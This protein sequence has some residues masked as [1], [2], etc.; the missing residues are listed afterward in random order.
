MGKG[1]TDEQREQNLMKLVTL[2]TSMDNAQ[3]YLLAIAGNHGE[4]VTVSVRTYE[5]HIVIFLG[6]GPE[7]PMGMG[8]SI[9]AA[10]SNALGH[11][12]TM[13]RLKRLVDEEREAMRNERQ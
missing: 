11:E 12:D 2:S 7:A 10:I 13:E 8:N 4:E 6:K 9:A 3:A 1:L 5:P